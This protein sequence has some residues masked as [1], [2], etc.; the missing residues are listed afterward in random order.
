MPWELKWRIFWEMNDKF[1]CGWSFILVVVPVENK[2]VGARRENFGFWDI[3][4]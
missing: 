1:D 2:G 3:A 4:E